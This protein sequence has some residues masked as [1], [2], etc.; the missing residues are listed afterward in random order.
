MHTP[1][2]ARLTAC[3]L[4]LATAAFGC[5]DDSEPDPFDSDPIKIGFKDGRPGMSVLTGK[6]TYVGFEPHVAQKVVQGLLHRDFTSLPVTTADWQEALL[7][8]KTN[9]NKVDLVIADISER[10]D[11]KKD[12]DLAGPYLQT[13]LGVLLKASDTREINKA[14]DL[15]PLAV[16]AQEKTTAYSTLVNNG[17]RPPVTATDLTGCM[18]RLNDGTAEA[19]LADYVVLQGIA[20]NSGTGTAHA[21]RV[22]R[23]ARIGRPQY[24]MMM[25]PKGHQKACELLRQ[26]IADY[27]KDTDWTTT[28]KEDLGLDDF[29]NK[30]IN[31][32]FQPVTTSVDDRCSA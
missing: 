6:G 19:V 13:P 14:E 23:N 8:G 10:D 18:D 30:E 1:R 9:H 2:P 16:C 29:T 32:I 17:G 5:S 7:D 22:P 21:Y 27:L 20:I 4:L 31:D 24:L 15:R 25:L 3:L 28:L 12:F 11:L 26:A